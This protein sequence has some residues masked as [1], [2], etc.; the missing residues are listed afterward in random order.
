M[1]AL[2]ALLL[3][4]S[5]RAQSHGQSTPLS[6]S[7]KFLSGDYREALYWW[8][9]IEMCRKLTLTG[10]VLLIDE[11]A[12]QAR[13]LVALMVSIGFLA[14]HLF[15]MPFKRCVRSRLISKHHDR[16]SL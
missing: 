3:R 13:T 15:F 1:P 2:Y 6:H 16:S 8:E 12:E 11:G 4:T 7:S 10:W 14:L 9:P 5:R